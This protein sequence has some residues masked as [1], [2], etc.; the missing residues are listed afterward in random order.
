MND[1][2]A[3]LLD[4]AKNIV[5][6]ARR[7]SYGTPEDNFA[8]IA[9][10]WTTYVQRR[11]RR[12]SAMVD[13]IMFTPADVAAM[14]V[15]MKAARLAE[16]P[17]HE[18]SWTDIAGY[19]ACGWRC[20][21]P[22]VEPLEAMMAAHAARERDAKPSA[23]KFHVTPDAAE[24]I[25]EDTLDFARERD[26]LAE[27]RAIAAKLHDHCGQHT[28]H[29]H[30]CP[31]C[32]DAKQEK[33]TYSRGLDVTPEAAAKIHEEHAQRQSKGDAD[34]TMDT[35][36]KMDLSPE[37]L[38]AAQAYLDIGCPFEIK[39]GFVVPHPELRPELVDPATSWVDGPRS[40]R[41]P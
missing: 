18:D 29:D 38:R 6:G 3:D 1:P 37:A 4:H 10:F 30:I 7:A 5:T 12:G 2:A 39:E 27:R 20:A 28:E 14:T 17:G 21:A 26:A 36:R 13:P 11:F 19:A 34:R 33:D 24:R 31:F 40:V 25:R 41:S 32:R 22:N 23:V 35:L 15:L 9:N 16:T 8:C